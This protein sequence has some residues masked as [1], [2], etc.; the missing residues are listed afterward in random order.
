[1]A[2]YCI[3]CGAQNDDQALFCRA[4]GQKLVSEG[5]QAGG[6]TPPPS[7]A[8]VPASTV[9]TFGQTHGDHK[10]IMG[11][12][13]FKDGSGTVTYSASRESTLHQNY[14]ILQG[15]KKIIYMKHKTHMNAVSYELQDGSGAPLGELR[16]QFSHWQGQLPKFSYADPQ[17]NPR[18]A[19][20]WEERSFDFAIADPVSGQVFAQARGEL[21]GGLK[22]DLK[23]LIRQDHTISIAEGTSLPL[24]IVLAFCVAIAYMPPG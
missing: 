19:V 24:P 10:F 7:A 13:D 22:G 18:A 2:K 16:C 5:T 1:M 11:S 14:T 17:G 23:A 15:Q 21:P 20:V 9:L 8:P 4:C 3:R 12:V 6:A